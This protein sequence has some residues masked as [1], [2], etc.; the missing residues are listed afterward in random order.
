MT[1]S[2]KI[3]LCV[4]LKNSK[5]LDQFIEDC[6]RDKVFLIAVVGDGCSH[7]EDLIDETVV[8]DGED[9]TRFMLTSSHPEESVDQVV[10]FAEMIELEDGREGVQIVS[11]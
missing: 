6:L 11:L 10:A 9:Q 7:I 2:P 1:Y 4:P 5:A 8:G 3:V